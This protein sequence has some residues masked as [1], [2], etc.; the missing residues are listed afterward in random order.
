MTGVTDSAGRSDGERATEMD[1]HSRV[2][3]HF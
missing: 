3:R 2:I 1:F